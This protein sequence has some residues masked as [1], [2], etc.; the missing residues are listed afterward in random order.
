MRRWVL[1]D[2]TPGVHHPNSVMHTAP[3]RCATRPR[4]DAVP[5]DVTTASQELPPAC[6]AHRPGINS[7]GHRSRRV[8]AWSPA[9]PSSASTGASMLASTTIT[10]LPQRHGRLTKRH[11]PTGAAASPV[12]DFLDRRM[13]GLL[14]QPST[15]VLLQRLMCRN[16]TAPQYRMRLLR[17]ILDLHAGHGAINGATGSRRASSTPVPRSWATT[18]ASRTT[19]PARLLRR[20]GVGATP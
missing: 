13:A 9:S 10:I 18:V 17:H 14:D 20:H 3:H 8:R 1:N 6:L 16:R 5:A 15:Q 19:A 4:P 2:S 12:Q 7:T 11:L